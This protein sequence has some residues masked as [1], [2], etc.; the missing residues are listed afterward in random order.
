MNGAARLRIAL[1]AP[2]VVSSVLL[3]GCMSDPT[4]G[5]GRSASIQLAEDLTGV[6]SL[7]PKQ[8]EAIAYEPRP[9]LVRPAAGQKANLPA[10]QD[11]L[12]STGNPSWPES[13]EAKRARLK[14][15]ITENRDNPTY[16]SPIAGAVASTETGRRLGSGDIDSPRAHDA[17]R[18]Y[19]D[20]YNT[21]AQR[22]QFNK[23]LAEER[24]GSPTSRK[25]LSE[26]PLV[27]RAPA[28]T[29]ATDDVGEDELKKERRRKA[30]ARKGSGNSWRDIIPGL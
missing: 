25:Y 29:A 26:P 13:P 19:G 3:A 18:R 12:A 7:T 20:Q 21:K 23:R 11:R 24:Q 27:Y 15:E 9:D 2:L 5:T 10:P 30:E 16:D 8:R 6:L 17:G 28:A 22:E 14:K 1:G 4:Y